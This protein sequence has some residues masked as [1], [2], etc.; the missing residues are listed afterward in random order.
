[1]EGDL[2]G[3]SFLNWFKK[4]GSAFRNGPNVPVK[5]KIRLVND[6]PIAAKLK[7]SFSPHLQCFKVFKI[8][9]Q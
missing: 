8:V 4:D 9:A 6:K 5:P 2:Y 1:V 7:C 3:G